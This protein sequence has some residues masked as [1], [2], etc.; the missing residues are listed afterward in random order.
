MLRSFLLP[1]KSASETSDR[2][3]FVSLKSGALAPTAGR[4]PTVSIGLPLSVILAMFLLSPFRV[5]TPLAYRLLPSAPVGP[6]AKGLAV[7]E[8]REPSRIRPVSA[9]RREAPR[10]DSICGRRD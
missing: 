9:P 8:D 6:K 3:P 10:S 5:S 7:R 1:A 2:S 4:F